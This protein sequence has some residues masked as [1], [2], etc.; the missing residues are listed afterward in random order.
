MIPLYM[1]NRLIP[2]LTIKFEFLASASRSKVPRASIGVNWRKF[3]VSVELAL[4][5]LALY[6]AKMLFWLI[7]FMSSTHSPIPYIQDW[8][9]QS[10]TWEPVYDVRIKTG[11]GKFSAN[12]KSVRHFSVNLRE[13]KQGQ[14]H[15]YPSCVW[16]GRGCIWGHLITW[17]GAVRPKTANQKKV[18]QTDGPM[19]GRSGVYSRVARDK[20]SW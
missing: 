1:L 18:W 9:H 6:R 20:N 14:I 2:M 7:S 5:Y 16:V 11:S 19:D 4:V 15:G 3:I 8:K 13:R 17:A 12:F 10:G